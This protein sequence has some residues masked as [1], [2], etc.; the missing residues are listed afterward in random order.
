[1]LYLSIV[2]NVLLILCFIICYIYS[3]KKVIN[4]KF[5]AK[6]GLFL[7]G[8]MIIYFFCLILTI[9]FG[10]IFHNYLTLILL[11]FVITPFII[12]YYASYKKIA[13]YTFIQISFLVMSLTILVMFL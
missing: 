2:I 4:P 3:L 6:L 9:L 12:G 11:L 10:F 13:K 5:K 8:L 7:C 1:M